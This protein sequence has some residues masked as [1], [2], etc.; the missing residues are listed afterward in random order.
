MTVQQIAREL[1]VILNIK[2]EE[3]SLTVKEAGFG[4]GL[5]NGASVI[6]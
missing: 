1:I 3:T 2:L 5:W 6:F 4:Q